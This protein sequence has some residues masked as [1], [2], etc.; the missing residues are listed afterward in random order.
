L[1]PEDSTVFW[2]VVVVVP[3]GVVTVS[4]FFVV[5]LR[6]QPAISKNDDRV[7]RLNNVRFMRRLLGKVFCGWIP[8][9]ICGTATKGNFGAS[10]LAAKKDDRRPEFVHLFKTG[11]SR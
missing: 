1:S 2:V 11:W 9:E 3:P 4:V 7:T 6:S 8:R 5:T 10:L